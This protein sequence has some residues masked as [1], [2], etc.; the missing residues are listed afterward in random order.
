MLVVGQAL[1]GL[2]LVLVRH[3]AEPRRADADNQELADDEVAAPSLRIELGSSV[4]DGVER[5]LGAALR[6]DDWKDLFVAWAPSKNVSLTLAYVDL[7]QVAG[8]LTHNKR[9]AGGYLA[10]QAGF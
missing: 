8:A 1:L 5:H 10:V 9:Q 3:L 6:E 7:G 4:R 2:V